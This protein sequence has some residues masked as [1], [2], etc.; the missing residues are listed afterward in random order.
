MPTPSPVRWFLNTR[1][2]AGH[3][4][5]ACLDSYELLGDRYADS[6]SFEYK[7]E[8]VY[9]MKTSYII[10]VENKRGFM[11]FPGIFRGSKIA[12]GYDIRSWKRYSELRTSEP[13]F[14][15]HTL[16]K[17]PSVLSSIEIC[18]MRVVIS[19]D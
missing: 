7:L 2:R 16:P 18:V 8:D 3:E 9:T 10:I 12:N 11:S 13:H 19:Y 14:D 6:R 1:L 15:M 4:T 17:V 5:V